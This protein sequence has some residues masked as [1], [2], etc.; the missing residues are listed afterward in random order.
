MRAAMASD[1][2]ASVGD[3]LGPLV[4]KKVKAPKKGAAK[5]ALKGVTAWSSVISPFGYSIRF[6]VAMKGKRIAY[7]AGPTAPGG[8]AVK[9]AATLA[10]VVRS[11]A[12]LP[13]LVGAA[14]G[15]SSM[16]GLNLG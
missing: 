11:K 1:S 8:T 7:A 2:A 4:W 6:T 3:G 16:N 13:L 15:A 9:G 5:K 12:K 14:R 10:K